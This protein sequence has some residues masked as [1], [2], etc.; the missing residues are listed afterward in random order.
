MDSDD[1]YLFHPE[2]EERALRVVSR[3]RGEVSEG[4]SYTSRGAMELVA[5]APMDTSIRSSSGHRRIRVTVLE[6]GLESLLTK[7][8]EFRVLGEERGGQDEDPSITDQV[9]SEHGRHK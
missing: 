6:V 7:A 5:V 4:P 9:L 1:V 2:D 3:S 8:V